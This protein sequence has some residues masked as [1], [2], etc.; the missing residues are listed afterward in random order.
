M[1]EKVIP[2]SDL[3]TVLADLCENA[4]LA[5]KDS[6]RKSVLLVIGISD[7]CYSIDVFDSGLPFEIDTLANLGLKNY[8]PRRIGWKRYRACNDF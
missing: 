3:N 7:G 5:A 2:E 8:H 1:V 6:E 4:I